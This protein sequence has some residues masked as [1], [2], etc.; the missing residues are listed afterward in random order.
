[1]NSRTRALAESDHRH[2]WHPFTQH[3]E[4]TL[5]EAL[6]IERA[7]GVHLVDTEGRRY[8]DG[9]SSLW[10]NVHGHRVP[11]IDAAIRAQLDQVAHTTLLGLM[12]VKSIELA[13]RLVA[14]T[15]DPLTRVF[16]SDS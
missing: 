3:D 15:P 12:S 16:F 8:L 7:E 6:V 5:Q 11:E 10:T 14:I 1:M 13:E 9:V 4:W 2:L